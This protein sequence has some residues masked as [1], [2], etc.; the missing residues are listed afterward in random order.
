MKEENLKKR[1]QRPTGVIDAVI[2]TDTFNEVDDQYALVY[3]LQSGD[4]IH[5]KGIYAAP[6][7]NEKAETPEKGM[8]LSYSEIQNVLTMM[9]KEMY[10]PMVKKGSRSYLK[11]EHTP[12]LSE[13]AEALIQLSEN[14]DSENQLYVIAIGAI[15]NIASALLLEP[16]LKERMVVVWL[17]G[18]AHHWP[19]KENTE[20]NMVQD[21]AAARVVFKSG[22]PLVQIPCMGVVSGFR[23]SEPELLKYLKGKNRLCDYLAERTITE[24][25]RMKQMETWSKPIWDVTTVAWLLGEQ[26]VRDQLVAKP[27]PEYDNTYDFRT[28]YGMMR[29][30]YHINRDLLFEDVFKK[31]GAV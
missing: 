6:F 27:I 1:L 20:F 18:Q 9:G 5:T 2:D 12:V 17:G 29:Y 15:T 26:F 30:A 23:I 22:V 31:L 14:Y 8:E 21:V 4:R 19:E 25:R 7:S 16:E 13:A 10:L 3:L 28:D 24:T 11:D